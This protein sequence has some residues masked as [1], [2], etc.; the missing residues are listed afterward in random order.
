MCEQLMLLWNRMP[1][2]L[3]EWFDIMATLRDQAGDSYKN[4]SLD[5]LLKLLEGVH[6]N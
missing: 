6:D 2:M 4:I 1:L 3:P 5:T